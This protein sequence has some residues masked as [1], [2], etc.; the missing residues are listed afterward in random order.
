MNTSLR[1][2]RFGVLLVAAVLLALGLSFSAQKNTNAASGTYKI[3]AWNDLG[4]HC[5]NQDFS[6]LA[7]L[8][9]Y[10]NLWVQVIQAG[11]PPKLVTSG[12]SV[13]YSYPDNTYS[14]GKTNFWSYSKALFGVELPDNIGLTGKGLSGS[15]DLKGDHFVAEG[16]PITEFSDSAPTV[17]QPFQLATVVV[18]DTATGTVL[19]TQSVVTPTSSE[20]RCDKCHSDTGAAKPQAPT[21]KIETNILQLHDE[22]Q[23]TSLMSNRPVL[24]ASCH[25]S[26][27]LGAPGQAGVPNLS[28]AMHSQHSSVIPNT[29]DG[30]Y[31]CH[32]G[33]QTRCLRDV[34][35]TEEG[36]TCVSC[37]GGM[38]Q[39]AA[40][41]NPW[42]NE[43][44]CDTCH[45]SGQHNQDNALYRLSKGHG[46]LY[47]EACHDST[48]AIA[49]SRE[50]NDAIKFIALQGKNGPLEECS[51]C[52]TNQPNEALGPHGESN[53]SAMHTISGNAGVAGATLHYTD[54]TTKTTTADASGNYS[55]KVSDKWTGKITPTKVGVTSFY[56]ASRSYIGL[57]ENKTGQ[58]FRPTRL[59][60]S[61]SAG[62]YDGYIRESSENS[63]I[64]GATNS[65]ST[66]FVVGDNSA[67]NQLR[68]LLSFDTS[69]LPDNA[70]IVSAKL[71]LTLKSISGTNPFD[72]HGS[73]LID[74]RNAY[75]GASP[76]LGLDDFKAEASL[77][78]AG[79]VSK[80]PDG[81]V[82]SGSFTSSALKLFNKTGLTQLRLRFTLDDNNNSVSDFLTFASGNSSVASERPVLQITYYVP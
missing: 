2:F 9:P 22:K 82:Y 80:S 40:N 13:T 59:N 7:V 48:H 72:T 60:T 39:V 15:M 79:S 62:G 41:P 38:T 16:I 25:G 19:A 26:N 29:L 71:K 28:K 1:R 30:C 12:I 77:A 49:P 43:P 8:P 14:V 20:M 73:L 64:G 54:G 57:T 37:H 47:C 31:N 67:K 56:P 75:F 35:N 3:L 18:K 61:T 68:G 58:N 4:M 63:G 78:S 6:D 42:L 10:N 69:S 46:N 34:M 5:Y 23:G 50:A 76:A 11:D 24:C 44:R 33:P 53:T 65:T 74:L 36:M 21:G 17:R 51:V 32:P 45:N 70:V 66:T 81:S 55:L 52:H 27:A